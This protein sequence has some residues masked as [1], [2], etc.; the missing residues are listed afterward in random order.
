MKMIKSEEQSSNVR[1][2]GAEGSSIPLP[3]DSEKY[4]KYLAE[5]D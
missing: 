5:A 1:E 3:F 2:L 4:R